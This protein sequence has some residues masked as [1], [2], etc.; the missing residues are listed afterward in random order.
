MTLFI[1]FLFFPVLTVFKW[2][3][4]LNSKRKHVM[5]WVFLPLLF[6]VLAV[7]STPPIPVWLL[8]ANALTLG[9]MEAIL[10]PA[11]QNYYKAQGNCGLAHGNALLFGLSWLSVFLSPTLFLVFSHKYLLLAVIAGAVALIFLCIIFGKDINIPHQVTFHNEIVLVRQRT[12]FPMKGLNAYVILFLA[13]VIFGSLSNVIYPLAIRTLHLSPFAVG[14]FVSTPLLSEATGSWLTSIF[15]LK[16]DRWNYL[17]LILLPGIMFVWPGTTGLL[18]LIFVWGAAAGRLETVLLYKTAN[19]N[20]A[21]SFKSMGLIAGI[22][23]TGFLAN[24]A[25]ANPLT[26]ILAAFYLFVILIGI[27]LWRKPPS[28]PQTVLPK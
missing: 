11:M 19:L 12:V 1:A 3:A 23:I 20:K 22:L 26:A 21:L 10:V 25:T 4:F 14:L 18:I 27:Y 5:A 15:P 28:V 17:L 13:G 2:K 9:F 16:D 6:V 8:S 24:W 7:F